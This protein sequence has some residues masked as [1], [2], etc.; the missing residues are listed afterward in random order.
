MKVLLF[1]DLH[2]HAWQYGSTLLPNGRNSR[3]QDT[4]N[5]LQEIRELA[6]KERVDGILFGGDMFHI[7]PGLSSMQIP[8][9]NAVYEEIALLK[10]GR[11][12]VGLLVGNHDQGDKAGREHSIFAFRSI[13]TVM[14][15]PGWHQFVSEEGEVLGVLAIPAH[16]DRDTL[17]AS[18]VENTRPDVM[19]TVLESTDR[20]VLLGHFGID[21]ALVG[22]NFRLRDAHAIKV[23]ELQQVGQGFSQIFLG[24]YHEPQQILPNAC[25]IGA[26]HH[27][28]WGDVGSVRGCRIWTTETDEIEFYQLEAA[29]KFVETN[30][31]DKAEIVKGHFVRYKVDKHIDTEDQDRIR[32]HI[33]EQLGANRVEFYIEKP[34]NGEPE[35]TSVFRPGM[36]HEDMIEAWVNS[37]KHD[38]DSKQLINM[39][40][41]MMN[42][43]LKVY[44]E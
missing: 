10:L 1:S 41:E 30:G 38:L 16:Q 42:K 22:T 35:R 18:M 37:S 25:Y 13:V 31:L 6:D 15:E 9:F 29:P 34:T 44:E 33:T 28:N 36:D 24:D 2:A 19:K 3:L 27:H 39:G 21:G 7:R 12:F 32:K 14:D 4:I 43:A 5:I 20:G 11:S 8:T 23:S 40:H 17:F 26:T